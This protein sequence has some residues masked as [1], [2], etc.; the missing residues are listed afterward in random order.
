MRD[1]CDLY[2]LISA[3]ALDGL[4]APLDRQFTETVRK[5]YK[6]ADVRPVPSFPQH[7]G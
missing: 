2:T 5:K 1:K 6:L 7:L 3:N 4:K